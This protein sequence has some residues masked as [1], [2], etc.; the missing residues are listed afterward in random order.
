MPSFDIVSKVDP[1]TIDNIIN[2]ARKEFV[3]R[4]DFKDSKS[5]LELNKK[6]LVLNITTENEM[7]LESIIDII[8]NRMIKQ[9]VNPLCL[10]ITKAHYAS[11]LLVKKEIK[12]KQGLDKDAARKIMADI[13]S[14]KTKAT[15]QI[16]DLTIRVTSKSL[17]ELQGIM[18]MIKTKDY[19]IPLQFDNFK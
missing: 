16:N 7:R 19:Q 5:E 1:Q 15:A 2:I 14:L 17:N 3:T 9:Q 10:D 6:D 12:L 8:R 4:F 13:K 18:Q 11:G